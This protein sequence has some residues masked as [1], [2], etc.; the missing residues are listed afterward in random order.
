[1]DCISVK[2]WGIGNSDHKHQYICL[3]SKK[4]SNDYI[5]RIK[6]KYNVR[7][8]VLLAAITAGI[9]KGLE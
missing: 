3:S 4:V 2:P 5:K 9:R 1:M 6:N 8:S 7:S